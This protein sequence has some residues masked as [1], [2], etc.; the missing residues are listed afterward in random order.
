MVRYGLPIP[1]RPGTS[2]PLV[3]KLF[4]DI[5]DEQSIEDDLSTFSSHVV[6]L[7]HMVKHADANTLILIDEAGTGTDP[8]EGGALAQAALEAFAEVD[9]RVIVTT[10]HGALKAFAHETPAVENGSMQ[11][12]P[13]TLSPT[14]RFQA[15]IPGSSYAFEIATRMKLPNPVVARARELVGEQTSALEDL[16]AQLEART[17]ELERQLDESQRAKREAK[18]TQQ[19]YEDLRQKL[20]ENRDEIEAKA[21]AQA[22]AIVKG[23][24]SRIERTVREIKEA[25]AEREATQ[26]ARERMEQ[27]KQSVVNRK[28]KVDRKRTRTPKASKPKPKAQN[29]AP[30]RGPIEVGDQV[31]LDNGSATGEVM[32]IEGKEAEVAFGAMRSRVKLKRLTKVAGPRRQQVQIRTASSVS[33]GRPQL[34]GLRARPS[35]DVRGQRVDEAISSVTQLLDDAVVANLETV[36]ILHGKGTGAL[37]L[38][39]QEHLAASPDVASFDEAHPEHGGAGVTEVRLLGA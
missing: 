38:A 2:I 32:T 29:G 12:D 23:A 28:K 27:F 10:H 9:A 17:A 39:I 25:E 11:F 26:L 6:R 19:K 37:R 14:Y 31:V 16:I 22:E 5:G 35:I 7:R 18:Q 36:R 8:E 13:D 20:N 15:G 34:R 33:K 30:P 21:L 1:C 3:D 4:V 24:N